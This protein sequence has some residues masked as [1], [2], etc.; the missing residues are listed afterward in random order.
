MS[1]FGGID[2][3]AAK[4][5]KYLSARTEKWRPVRFSGIT[6][7]L[8]MHS[9]GELE[10]SFMD[11]DPTDLA[12]RPMKREKSPDQVCISSPPPL[13]GFLSAS[14]ALC[15]YR[16]PRLCCALLTGPFSSVRLIVGFNWV[17]LEG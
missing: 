12:S 6:C 5:G 3:S 2:G 9:Q 14:L 15:C 11:Q 10:V 4:K 13:L 17:F 1:R 7:S 16:K 8:A